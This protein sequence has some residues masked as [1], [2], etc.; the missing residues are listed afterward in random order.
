[1]P[2][3]AEIRRLLQ[4]NPQ[5]VRQRLLQSGLSEAQIRAALRAR[6]IPSNALDQYLSGE[7]LDSTSVVGDDQLSALNALGV[8]QQTPDGLEIVNVDV[9]MRLGRDSLLVDSLR[10]RGPRIFGL[11]IFSRAT[12]RFQPLLSGPVPDSYRIGPDDQMVLVLTGE[13]ELAHEITVT[14]E[15]FIVIPNVG[16]VSVG[17][18]TMG[19]LRALL[20]T[21]L[22]RS[23]SGITRG[24]T[25]FSVT[26]SQLRTNQIY[27]TGEVAQPGAYQLA[28]VATV[29]NALYAAGGPTALGNMRGIEI[30]R[31]AGEGLTVDL[32]PYLL[33]GDISG[34]VI[35]EQGD[36]VFVPLKGRRVQLVGSV[37]RPAFY[38]L[39]ESEGLSDVL[40]AA[41]GFSPNALRERVT[42][43]R[44][45]QP[46]A[47]GP[48]LANRAAIDLELPASIDSTSI[49]YLG[50]VVVPPIGLQD[51]DSIVVDSIPPL[52]RGYY[53][54]IAGMV[55]SP[56]RF[57]WVEGMSLR[58]LVQLARGPVVGADLTEA[59]V[60]RMPEQ[61]E[62]GLVAVPI[63]VPLDSSYLRTPNPGGFRGPPGAIF[64]PAGA[65]PEF[66]LEP[67]DHV[68]ILPQPDFELPQQARVVGE[69]ARPGS[70]TLLSKSDRV[71]DLVERSGGLLPTGY[72][73]GARLYRDIDSD[74]Q[75][76]GTMEEFGR[77]NLDLVAAL[78]DPE[79]EA[80]VLL[81]AGDSLYIPEYSPTVTVT[82]AVNSP[83]TVMYQPGAG[84]DYYIA[85]AGGYRSDADKGGASVR[86]ANGTA[87]TRSRFLFF[88]SYPDPGPGSMISV[89]SEDPE[90]GSEWV[91]I[92]GPALSAVGSIVALII[93]VS[94]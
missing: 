80:N 87:R 81:E 40:A 6:G 67:Y 94:R 88:T 56:G 13:V 38:E 69:V 73:A 11:D 61:R 84:F 21:R 66:E 4:Q 39:S 70:Y 25:S 59:E 19:D 75:R 5:A 51:G 91:T 15:G 86:Y 43:H 44:I 3:E 42:I 57:P 82:G 36:V 74:V 45:L 48:G 23:Y 31:R 62:N 85:N 35:L 50:G 24:T 27:V 18:L 22:A 58:D 34:D 93:A 1:M 72:P 49:G 30:R 7:L 77:I 10:A 17:N 53:V 46:G 64:P 68:L 26:I 16:Q 9:G 12:S 63:S 65:S 60:A 8:V 41:G 2:S 79:S 78:E 37:N 47:R 89:P 33:Q 55:Q 76:F 29:M 83:V 92:L 90:D 71:V 28:S 32:Y 20:R 52:M 14:R 54:S